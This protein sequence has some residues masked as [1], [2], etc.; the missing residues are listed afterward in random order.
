MNRSV[1][2][3]FE[4]TRRLQAQRSNWLGWPE[5]TSVASVDVVVDYW[6]EEK[7]W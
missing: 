5:D 4:E 7:L 1:L 3:P 2:A 6:K